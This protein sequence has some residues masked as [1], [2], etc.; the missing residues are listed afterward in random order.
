MRLVLALLAGLACSPAG[1]RAADP[2]AL[3]KIVNGKCVPHEQAERDPSPCSS[4]DLAEGVEKGF[5]VLKDRDGAAQFL[6]I[7]TARISGIDDPAILDPHA[8][9]YWAAAWNARYFVEER[10]NTS[11]PRD[12]IV[13]AINSSVGRSQD[14][15][16]IH[17]DCV[18]PDV[19][20]AL[21]GNLDKVGEAWAPFPIPL[22]GHSYQ[23][24]RINQETLDGV[25]PFRVLVNGDPQTGGDISKH[26][27]V[28]VGETFADGSNGFVLLDDHANLM[29]ADRASGEQLQDHT[30]AVAR[31]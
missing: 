17:I 21:A 26:T 15:L 9:N 22:A 27:L 2:S 14:Q 7:P 24:I 10:L 31:N 20:K 1:A 12:A 28:L 3:W 25:D 8:T 16:H 4:V 13:L 29:A 30:C 18:R 11:L 23:A 6:L 19:R 5:A